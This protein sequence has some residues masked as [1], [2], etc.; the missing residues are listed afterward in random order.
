MS[1]GS[2]ML[3]GIAP[4]RFGK[5]M[6]IAMLMATGALV[7]PHLIQ[8]VFTTSQRISGN[9]GE[10]VRNMIIKSGNG[11]RIKKFGEETIEIWGD[12]PGDIRKINCY[13]ANPRI[14]IEKC[15]RVCFFFCVVVCDSNDRV[16]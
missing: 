10:Y 6:A 4:R 13:P 2:S 9:M 16:V 5:S 12:S 3:L 11:H 8:A 14:S 1:N 15:C 7:V